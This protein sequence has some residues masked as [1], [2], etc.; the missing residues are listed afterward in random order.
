MAINQS[1]PA[2]CDTLRTVTG[3]TLG[4]EGVATERFV[5]RRA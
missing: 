3:V 1:F 2:S 5:E 4:I